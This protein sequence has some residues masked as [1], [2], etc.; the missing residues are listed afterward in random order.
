M[1]KPTAI[2]FEKSYVYLDEMLD[3]LR[4]DINMSQKIMTLYLISLM[5]ENK[6][7]KKSAQK[8]KE[9]AK[10]VSA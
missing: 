8:F 5:Y 4:E 10:N 1:F 2:Y 6:G 7:D 3:S 9:M